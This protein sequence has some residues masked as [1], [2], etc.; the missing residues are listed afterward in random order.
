MKWIRINYSFKKLEFKLPS[1]APAGAAILARRIEKEKADKVKEL[2]IPGVMVSP[3]TQR[4]Y[5]ND[6]FLSH[7]LGT[8]NSDGVGL[9]GIE[10]K[11]DRVFIWKSWIKNN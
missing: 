8:T 5:P 10:L 2:E 11:Y 7:V 1:G 9:N 3:D 4:Y 6:N